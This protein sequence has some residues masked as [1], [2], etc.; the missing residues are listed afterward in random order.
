M[1]ENKNSEMSKGELFKEILKNVEREEDGILE[2][3]N[4][5]VTKILVAHASMLEVFKSKILTDYFS[6]KGLKNPE[7]VNAIYKIHI[8]KLP[9][10]GNEFVRTMAFV[11]DKTYSPEEAMEK[12]EI[13]YYLKTILNF[14][15]SIIQVTNRIDAIDGVNF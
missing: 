15:E 9:P 10:N 8:H 2:G 6:G 7:E 12:P 5:L 11:A 4:K 13:V 14:E 3:A 1:A